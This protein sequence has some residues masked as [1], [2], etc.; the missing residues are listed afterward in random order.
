MRID[1]ALPLALSLLE[2]LRS[3]PGVMRIELCGSLR[4]RKE[5]IKDIDILVSSDEPRPIMERFV[6]LPGVVQV[7]GQGD[8]KSSVIV[9]D[10]AMGRR[11]VMMHADL[12]VVNDEQFPFALHYFTGSKEHNIAM[13]Q[14]GHRTAA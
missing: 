2:G 14:R 10:G 7:I 11:R 1:Q 5:T 12:R 3:L 13:R 4:R 8:T 9:S 6:E